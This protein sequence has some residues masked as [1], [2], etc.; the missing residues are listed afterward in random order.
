M[1]HLIIHL[2]DELEI[3]G[4]IATR[5]FYPIKRYLYVLKKYLKNKTKL[6]ACMASSYNV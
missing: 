6:E 4:P 2:V 5:W 1:T 3:C